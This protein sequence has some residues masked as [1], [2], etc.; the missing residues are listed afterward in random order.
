MAISSSIPNSKLA[1]SNVVM[2]DF[3]IRFAFIRTNVK[4]VKKIERHTNVNML[5]GICINMATIDNGKLRKLEDLAKFI[6]KRHNTGAAEIDQDSYRLAYEVAQLLPRWVGDVMGSCYTC[7]TENVP[8]DQELN[9][10]KC[11]ERLN[12]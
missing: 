6:L 2:Q 4:N 1:L 5:I 3:L 9:C 7:K 12:R 8:I 10:E 11:F